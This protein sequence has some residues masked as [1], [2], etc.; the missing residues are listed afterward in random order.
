MYALDKNISE[1]EALLLMKDITTVVNFLH[2]CKEKPIIHRDIKPSNVMV[3]L[4]NKVYLIDFG[5]VRYY[6]ETKTKDTIKLGTKGYASPEQYNDNNQTDIRTDI[7]GI[8]ITM[9]YLLTKNDPSEPPYEIYPIRYHNKNYSENLEGIIKK[10]IKL[11][12]DERYQ[13]CEELLFDINELLRSVEN[14]T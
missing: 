10:C 14:G 8:G 3:D 6:D 7:Y 9:Y 11:N 2:T 4:N 12:P 1:N 13:N 5:S